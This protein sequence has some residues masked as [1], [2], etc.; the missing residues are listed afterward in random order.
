MPRS[1][2]ASVRP[3]SVAAVVAVV[4]VACVLPTGATAAT[5]RG[6]VVERVRFVPVDGPSL[7]ADGRAFAGVVEVGAHGGGLA[8]VNDVGF[9]DYVEGITEVPASW[10]AEAQKAQAIAARTYALHSLLWTR[11]RG[12]AR[13]LGADI[14]ATQSCQ[15]YT[16]L[17]SAARP[18][19]GRW[20][21]A[22]EATRGQLLLYR[23]GPILA[24]YSSTNGGRTVRGSRPYLWE[25][26][27]P[28]DAASPYHRWRVGFGAAEIQGLFRLAGPLVAVARQADTV[29]LTARQPDGVDY[30]LS[31]SAAHFRAEVNRA[32]GPRPGL[33]SA[34][35]SNRYV[36]G[37]EGDQ[38][39]V[40][41]GGWGHGIGMSQYGALGKARRGMAAADILAAYY[42]GIR[43]TYVEPERLPRTIRVVVAEGRSAVTV[44]SGGAFQV[45]DQAGNPLV[46]GGAGAWRIEPA[47]G[48]VR[49]IPPDGYEQP[50]RAAALDPPAPAVGQQ[51]TVSFALAAPAAVTVKLLGPSGEATVAQGPLPA[52]DHRVALQQAQ[53]GDW[54]VVVEATTGRDRTTAVP[55]AFRVEPAI[56]DAPAPATAQ[57]AAPAVAADVGPGSGPAKP[58]PLVAAA[59]A[60]IV[61]VAA[62]LLGRLRPTRG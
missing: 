46:G 56:P 35:P 29:V 12:I 39:V 21:A 27:D 34:V 31:M 10:P 7:T 19:G 41:G 55:I 9:E 49:V 26:P 28:D 44:A 14:C 40:D 32:F 4:L 24:Q 15:V 47:A 48:G 2:P 58:A 17:A 30:P 1:R 8:V 45:L 59:G 43:P 22:V 38:V 50:L 23:G 37:L 61:L 5:E 6:W 13:P 25:V 51:A 36:L 11:Q 16:G 60:L 33:P 20:V 3:L 62:G 52:G 18:G 54:Q 42:A 57:S 53:P